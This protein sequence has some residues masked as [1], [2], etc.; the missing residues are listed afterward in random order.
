MLDAILMVGAAVIAAVPAAPPNDKVQRGPVPSWV[1]PSALLPAPQD[2]SGM[3][4]VRRSDTFVHLDAQG[5]TIYSG[6]HIKILHPN[7]LQAGNLSLAWNPSAGAPSVHAIRVHRDGQVTDILKDA[8]FEILRRED[9]LEA[10]SLNGILTAVLRVPDLRVGDELEVAVTIPASDPTLRLQDSGFVMLPPVPP[11]GRTRFDVSWEDGQ[12]PHFKMTPDMAAAAKQA[13]RRVTLDL[14]NPPMLNVPQDAPARYNWQRAVEFSDFNDWAEI[15]RLFAPLYA[16]AATLGATS[17]LKAEA[18]RIAASHAGE[19]DRAGA[20]LKLVQQEV[21]YIYVGLGAG[22]LTPA[23]AEETWAR[24]WGDCK[25]KTVLLLALLNELGIEAAPVLVN[26]QGADDGLDSRLPSP[27]LFDHILVRARVNGANLWLDGTLPPVAAPSTEPALP[28][29]WTLPVTAGGSGLERREWHP[30]AQ[31]D[32]VSLYEIDAR[33]G[34]DKPARITTTN[35]VRGIEG[36]AAYAQFS[37][38]PAAQLL[39]ALR[40]QLV[41]DTWQTIEDAQWRYDAKARA[42]VLTIRGTGMVD[43]VDE[44]AGGKSLILAGGGFNPP[45]K[46]VRAAGP[47]QDAP[48]YDKPEFVCH[49]TTV[50]LPQS[51]KPQQ[52]SFNKSFDTRMFGRNYYRAFEQRDGAI[53]MVRGSRTEKQEIDAA[54]AS[55]DNVRIA[56][57]DNSMG[58]IAFN[59]SGKTSP[60]SGSRVPAT[61]EL[62][63]TAGDVPCLAPATS[64]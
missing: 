62:D 17:P 49:A 27:S 28:Y 38:V 16:K 56:A 59:P 26:N 11:P 43:W 63:W 50:R 19:A 61:Y 54:S 12:K 37:G 6:Y 3:V 60:Q 18:R 51:T 35:I 31:P 41:G 48:Y 57:F 44:G 34:F 42:S 1:V 64:R 25:G 36:L 14:D 2:A 30:A 29:R 55:R 10:A 39:G 21:R 4:F 20:A 9:Q 45:S 52:W 5:Q 58:Q 23:T 15:S 24:R 53:R 32:S 22:N 33:A 7:A 46:R 47:F 13:E 40:E 8:S